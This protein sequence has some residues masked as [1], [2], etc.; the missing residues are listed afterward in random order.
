MPPAPV[1]HMSS[2]AA[3]PR[4]EMAKSVSPATSPASPPERDDVSDKASKLTSDP[5]VAAN[6]CASVRTLLLIEQPLSE[7]CS[8]ARV[9]LLLLMAPLDARSAETAG[10]SRQV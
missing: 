4:L 7:A 6:D 9:L 2:P 1:L 5:A 3:L 8:A 10:G